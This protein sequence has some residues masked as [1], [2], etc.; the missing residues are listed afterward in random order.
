MDKVCPYPWLVSSF[1]MDHTARVCCDGEL[2]RRTIKSEEGEDFSLKESFELGDVV[3]API[4][5]SLRRSFL[6]GELPDFCRGCE[7]KGETEAAAPREV[8]YDAYKQW[9]PLAISKTREDGSLP[10]PMYKSLDI[11]LGNICNLTCRMCRPEFS[12]K[13]APFYEEFGLSFTQLDSSLK[14]DEQKVFFKNLELIL[15]HLSHISFQGGEPT[16]SPWHQKI[17]ELIL[18]LGLSAKIELIYVTNATY[19]PVRLMKLWAKFD[20]ISFNLSLDAIGESYEYI[21]PPAKWEDVVVNLR[22]LLKLRAFVSHLK[23]DIQ[24]VFQAYNV[25][26][27]IDLFEFMRAHKAF[28]FDLPR[29]FYITDPPFLA[30]H[31]LPD[32][33]KQ[34]ISQNIV[35]FVENSSSPRQ[36]KENILSCVETFQKTPMSI[37]QRECFFE[38]TKFLDMKHKTKSERF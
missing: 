17:L 9:M 20:V 21:R 35:S 27:I 11:S 8:Y 24:C 12:Q 33:E 19:I 18:E 7:K 36:R 13:I 14:E 4:L 34:R 5:K 1:E 25:Y 6:R 3:N 10:G 38:Y 22:E 23:F 32:E 26:E 15:P 28:K 16:V 29:L 30:P 2:G 31:H 37:K